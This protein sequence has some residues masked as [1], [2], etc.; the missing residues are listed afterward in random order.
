MNMKKPIGTLLLSLCLSSAVFAGGHGVHWGYKGDTG[1]EHWGDLSEEF[2]MCKIGKNQ[3]PIDLRV[4]DAYDTNLPPLIFSYQSKTTSEIN[5]GHSIQVNIEP[6]SF[7]QIDGKRFELK[8]FHFHTPSENK[9]NG[10]FFPLEA[11][12]VHVSKEGEIAVVAVMFEHGNANKALETFWNGMPLT[13]GDVHDIMMPTEVIKELL[14]SDNREYYRFN[15]SLTTPPCSEG[16]RWFVMKKPLQVSE[17]Q[18]ARFESVMHDHN[19]RPVQP[20]NAR[21]ILK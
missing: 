3:S 19:N 21:V 5:N 1:P 10:K 17:K 4:M 11:H 8:Q 6:G 16:V 13:A 2:L 15:G 14:P 18:V 12:F 20:I 7:L 9:I